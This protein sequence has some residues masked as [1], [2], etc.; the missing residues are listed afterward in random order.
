MM[1]SQKPDGFFREHC[2]FV[3]DNSSDSVENTYEQIDKGLKE[4]GFL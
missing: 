2:Q 3:V 1:K 4:H